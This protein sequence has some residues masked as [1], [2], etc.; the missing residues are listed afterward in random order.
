M[1][2]FILSTAETTARVLS[3]GQVGL[4]LS[5]GGI[6]TDGVSS[7]CVAGGR[8]SD[9]GGELTAN[10]EQAYGATFYLA[11]DGYLT[12]ASTG[13]IFGEVGVN[14]NGIASDYHV[15]NAG[16]ISGQFNGVDI[17]GHNVQLYNAGQITG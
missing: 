9:R 14:M 15:T 12:V 1:T 11:G 6:M 7:V 2:S 17:T 8:A 10:G 5:T 3:N 16:T 4:V 13:V